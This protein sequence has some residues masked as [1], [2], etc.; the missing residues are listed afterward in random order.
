M[1]KNSEGSLARPAEILNGTT[2]KTGGETTQ[3]NQAKKGE[4]SLEDPNARKARLDEERVERS[5]LAARIREA[6][7]APTLVLSARRY[8][9]VLELLR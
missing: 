6:N 3:P 9:N 2:N 4:D 7:S 8:A 5:M 1:L